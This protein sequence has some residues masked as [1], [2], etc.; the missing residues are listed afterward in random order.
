MVQTKASV[1]FSWNPINGENGLYSKLPGNE[2]RPAGVAF[3]PIKALCICSNQFEDI[4]FT[5]AWE[6][7]AH[8]LTPW[9]V[10]YLN[11]NGH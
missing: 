7:K 8:I 5:I 4:C 10:Y 2:T 3:K 9:L 1:G 11:N 6:L